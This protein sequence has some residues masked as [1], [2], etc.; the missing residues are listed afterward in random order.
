M[1]YFAKLST[2]LPIKTT[3]QPKVNTLDGQGQT[4]LHRAALT[5]QFKFNIYFACVLIYQYYKKYFITTNATTNATFTTKTKLSV[6]LIKIII[7][8]KGYPSIIQTTGNAQSLRL[9]LQYGCDKS[10]ISLLGLT[11]QQM[12]PESLQKIFTGML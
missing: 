3:P 7:T 11:A 4:A 12:A 5:G 8:M 1:Y 6:L 9:L 10:I 2:Y